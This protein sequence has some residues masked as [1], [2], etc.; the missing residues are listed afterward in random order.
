MKL[1]ADI[2]IIGSGAAGG[3]L[4]ATLAKKTGKKILFSA[5]SSHFIGTGLKRF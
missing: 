3:V 4:A 5:I 2:V 1:N